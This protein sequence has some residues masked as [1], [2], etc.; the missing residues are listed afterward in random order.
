MAVTKINGNQISNTTSAIISTLSFL[1]TNSVFQLPTGT[2]EQRPT[3]V[4]YGTM[5]FNTTLDNA[6]IYKSDSDGTGVD[7]WGAIGGGGPAKGIDSTIR[8][9]RNTISEN[10]TVGPS[11]GIQYANGMSAGPITIANGFTV[12]VDTGGSWSIV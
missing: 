10:I 4:T 12:T 3:G 9:N 1:N 5:R 6:E 11:A 8:T 2:T 7:G